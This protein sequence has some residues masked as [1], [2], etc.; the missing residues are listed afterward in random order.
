M[1]QRGGSGLFGLEFGLVVLHLDS[2]FIAASAGHVRQEP[3]LATLRDDVVA[4]REVVGYRVQA[5]GGG[6]A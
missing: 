1:V 3:R 5:R 4:G 2:I 6:H